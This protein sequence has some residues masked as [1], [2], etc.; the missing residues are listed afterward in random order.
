MKKLFR[1][2]LGLALLPFAVTFPLSADPTVVS[3]Y[4]G[5][6][7][8]PLTIYVAS[9]LSAQVSYKEQTMQVYP[10]TMELADSGFFV[11]FPDAVTVYGPAFGSHSGGTLVTVP[12]TPWT[13]VSQE[14]TPGGD[15]SSGNPWTLTTTVSGGGV[16]VEQ[17]VTY[18]NGDKDAEWEWIVTNNS[19]GDLN[20]Q[21]VHAAAMYM[22][23]DGN[24]YGYHD[25]ATGAVGGYNQAMTWFEQLT[26]EIPAPSSY[27]VN[28]YPTIWSHIIGDPAGTGYGLQNLVTL[29]YTEIAAGLQ[30]DKNP[31]APGEQ[32]IIKDKW[33]FGP[34]P[35]YPPGPTPTPPPV[36]PATPGIVI[37]LNSTTLTAGDQFTVDVTVQPINQR[38]DAWA[39]IIGGGATYSMVLNNPTQIRGGLHPLI[40]GVNKLTSQFSGQLLNMQIP[41]GVT[42]SYQVIVALVP[43]GKQPSLGNAIPNFLDQKTV[44]IQ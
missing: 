12:P 10:P 26:P 6:N 18:V 41:P 24:A 30:W 27:E 29:A 9:D 16:N 34:N 3:V 11:F 5:Q 14:G 32:I 4:E 40:T 15:G 8:D 25:P 17:K 20:C 44:T 43:A 37:T 23:G 2:M 33:R 31:F 7:S 39:V 42:G 19:G 38:F 35:P 13:P 28:D 22:Q 1:V 21:F 36:P